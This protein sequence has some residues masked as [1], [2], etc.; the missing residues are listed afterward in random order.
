MTRPWHIR[1]IGI[2]ARAFVRPE[3]LWDRL[4]LLA[5]GWLPF[6]LGGWWSKPYPTGYRV[7][8]LLK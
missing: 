7:R 6:N 1:I 8:A 4:T 2:G 3:T 5:R